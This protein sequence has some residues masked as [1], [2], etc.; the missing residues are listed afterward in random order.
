VLADFGFSRYGA[1]D[2][3]IK[4]PRSQPWDAPEWHE[5]EF[6]LEA[7]SKTD[8]YAFGLLC[9]WWLFR[10]DSLADLGFPDVTVQD[11]F[12]CASSDVIA[13]IQAKKEEHV[14]SNPRV[15]AQLASS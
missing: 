6:T 9:F 2:D 14:G 5:R 11:A 13:A 1:K 10:D 3:L 8:V 12:T 15:G 4:L 7:A